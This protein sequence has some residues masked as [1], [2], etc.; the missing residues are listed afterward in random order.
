MSEPRVPRTRDAVAADDTPR[1]GRRWQI[2]GLAALLVATL[3]AASVAGA[4]TYAGWSDHDAVTDNH[5]GAGTWEPAVVEFR[6]VVCQTVNVREQ[7]RI[8]VLVP[9]DTG[10]DPMRLVAATIRFGAQQRETA[11][12]V[13][14]KGL[15]GLCE[16]GP[17]KGRALY[18]QMPIPGLTVDDPIACITATTDDGTPARGCTT[19]R[20]AGNPPRTATTHERGGEPDVV[21]TDPPADRRPDEGEPATLGNPSAPDAV[22]AELPADHRPADPAD[23]HA[24]DHADDHPATSD[25]AGPAASSEEP[26]EPRATAE[27]GQ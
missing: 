13:D 16:P 23:A 15:G 5:I 26:A 25:P 19:L 10:F 6:I 27:A 3:A 17:A 4:G 24:G 2:A 12:V 21:A 11:P 14:D 20:Y 18:F 8:R 22:Q 9:Q 1:A 7:G